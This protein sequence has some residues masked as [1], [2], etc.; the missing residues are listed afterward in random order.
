[1]RMRSLVLCWLLTAA[2]GADALSVLDP[3]VTLRVTDQPLPDVLKTISR[4][5]GTTLLAAI[6]PER[7]PRVSLEVD[8]LNLR[9]VLRAL[10]QESGLGCWPAA[11]GRVIVYTRP[12]GTPPDR[13]PRAEVPGYRVLLSSVTC[14]DFVEHALGPLAPLPAR[15][16][17]RV[18][19]AVDAETEVQARGL[20]GLDGRYELVLDGQPALP[21][22]QPMLP[23]TS[24]RATPPTVIW[25]VPGSDLPRFDLDFAPAA[26]TPRAVDTLSGSLIVYP[27][28]RERTFEFTDLR[29]TDRKLTDGGVDVTLVRCGPVSQGLMFV[30]LGPAPGPPGWVAELVLSLPAQDL[31]PIHPRGILPVF[32]MPVVPQV[33]F[34]WPPPQGAEAHARAEASKAIGEAM[35]FRS[36]LQQRAESDRRLVAGGGFALG[37]PFDPRGSLPL[38]VAETDQG[39][40]PLYGAGPFQFANRVRDGV[41]QIAESR[42]R[43]FL[44]K[45]AGTPRRLLVGVIERG[46]TVQKLPFA[47]RNVTLPT[48]G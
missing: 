22:P 9:R 28:A 17:L 25:P 47:F 46:S 33:E 38:T 15:R 3:P 43:M 27:D 26:T 30:P 34:G 36:Q 20:R 19:L 44:T 39:L 12:P 18:E 45:D 1:M 13:R 7:R 8:R 35:W 16:A 5:T 31:G 41:E 14:E 40:V 10:R 24:G 32:E 6:P 29:A 42:F 11:D 37:Q 4:Q 21:N 2:C 48:G 23:V